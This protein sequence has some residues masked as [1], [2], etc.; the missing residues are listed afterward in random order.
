[1]GG[2]GG[3]GHLPELRFPALPCFCFA[4]HF[5]FTSLYFTFIWPSTFTSL[6]FA[7]LY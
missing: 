7:L 6:D 5:E 2:D 1:M 3:K 4:L